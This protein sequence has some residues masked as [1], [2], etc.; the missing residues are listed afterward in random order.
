MNDA[1]FSQFQHQLAMSLTGGF[2]FIPQGFTS[3]PSSIE[4]TPQMRAKKKSNPVPVEKKTQ[5]CLTFK[6]HFHQKLRHK[7]LR[8][9]ILITHDVTRVHKA[10]RVFSN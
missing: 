8:I 10:K 7:S 2:P 5:V 3:S 6:N 4:N 9:Y 1:N